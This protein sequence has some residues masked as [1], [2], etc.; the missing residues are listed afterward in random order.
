M[1]SVQQQT[2]P[3]EQIIVGN[4]WE[5]WDSIIPPVTRETVDKYHED[6]AV[7]GSIIQKELGFVPQ[8]DLNAWWE[9]TIR[10]KIVLRIGECS[11]RTPVRD[12]SQS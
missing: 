11:Y 2:Y 7:D 9:E 10:G 12:Q 5:I 8:Y 1:E 6:I 3:A 4:M